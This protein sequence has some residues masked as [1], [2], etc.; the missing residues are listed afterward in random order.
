MFHSIASILRPLSLMPDASPFE[1]QSL[2]HFIQGSKFK[3]LQ[4]Y[5]ILLSSFFC[6]LFSICYFLIQFRFIL[7]PSLASPTLIALEIPHENPN[8][9]YIPLA[10]TSSSRSLFHALVAS[11]SAHA[12]NWN[13]EVDQKQVKK[14]ERV[15]LTLLEADFMEVI[16]WL[17]VGVGAGGVGV[18]AG[19]LGLGVGVG[20]ENKI[21]DNKLREKVNSLLAVLQTLILYA[22]TAGD[23]KQWRI[24]MTGA[25]YLLNQVKNYENFNG[26]LVLNTFL[27]ETIKFLDIQ[28]ALSLG[29]STTINY[30]GI[31]SGWSPNHTVIHNSITGMNGFSGEY[32]LILGRICNLS[33]ELHPSNS[34]VPLSTTSTSTS[35]SSM[36]EEIPI[37]STS[38]FTSTSNSTFSPPPNMNPISS[39]S[40]LPPQP[41]SS[42]S[43]F[44]SSSS[45]PIITPTT[46]PTLKTKIDSIFQD[47]ED[48]RARINSYESDPNFRTALLKRL[49]LGNHAG[50]L[51]GHFRFADTIYFAC[52]VLL[53]RVLTSSRILNDESMKFVYG[54]LDALGMG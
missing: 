44:F 46:L 11:G 31:E 8:Y 24:H 4:I 18:G 43:T 13:L 52:H 49:S 30:L 12:K 45:N 9:I 17:G 14:Q 19:G 21:D 47:L 33:A 36:M 15:T 27:L 2:G 40:T 54:G 38:T 1:L 22:T 20:G 7:P 37:P 16:K 29:K 51:V 10:L 48:T 3:L 28:T 50:N 6:F 39:A 32:L 23:I 42:S 26:P 35:S 53:A 5:E 41:S 25:A 34:S